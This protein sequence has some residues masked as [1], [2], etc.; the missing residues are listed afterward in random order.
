MLYSS[1]LKYNIHNIYFGLNITFPKEMFV[2]SNIEEFSTN[3]I[4]TSEVLF[5]FLCNILSWNN[6]DISFLNGATILTN[7][8]ALGLS[9]PH[10]F[11]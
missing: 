7:L 2:T 5:A 11:G 8:C 4:L 6:P 3:L 10:S 1:T 9:I